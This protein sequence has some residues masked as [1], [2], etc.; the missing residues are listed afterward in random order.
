MDEPTIEVELEAVKGL[1]QPE[2]EPEQGSENLNIVA[3]I[4]QDQESALPLPSSDSVSGSAA[5]LKDNPNI[6][7]LQDDIPTRQAFISSKL[8]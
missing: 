7:D 4:A 6:P 8:I 5:E 2:P 1:S 3:S